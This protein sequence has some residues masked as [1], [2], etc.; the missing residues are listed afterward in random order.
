MKS[1]APRRGENMDFRE[2][3]FPFTLG[4]MNQI[5]RLTLAVA[6]LLVVGTGGCTP[7]G[8]P[9]TIEPVGKKGL[10]VQP[11]FKDVLY[12]VDRD[13]DLYFTSQSI[14]V[15]RVTGKQVKQILLVR[16]FWVPKGGKTSLDPSSLNATMRYLVIGPDSM[17]QY[18][19]AGFVRLEDKV[20]KAK[21]RI[22]IMDADLRLTEKTE[23][24]ADTLERSRV[25]GGLTARRDEER[26]L[27]M[28]MAAQ[29][30][31]FYKTL[32]KAQTPA[33]SSTDKA[34]TIEAPGT[35]KAD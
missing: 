28:G 35:Q 26:A 3:K 16:V 11:G 25:R 33:T 10:A 30:E 22:R 27:E 13:G 15:D 31:F 17:G 7:L 6:V 20:G 19:G 4:V 29:R 8:R 24:F 32:G 1:S 14:G 5:W 2:C 12:R 9:L 23:N 18:E 34:A 21:M